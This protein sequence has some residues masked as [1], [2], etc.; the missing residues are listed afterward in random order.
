MNFKEHIPVLLEEVLTVFLNKDISLFIDATLG[1][2]GHA[3]SLLRSHP[4]IVRYH[5][6]DRDPKAIEIARGN[7]EEFSNKL[8]IHNTSFGNL[9]NLF[10][11]SSIDGILADI[12]LSSLQ[13]DDMTR[14]FSFKSDEAYLDMRM[15]YLSGR[16]AADVLNQCSEKELAD[17]FRELGE[18]PYW[19]QSAKAIVAFRRRNKFSTVGSLKESL[20][21]VFPRFRLRKKISPLTLIFQALRIYV[22]NELEELT[23]LIQEAFMLLADKG[24]FACISFHSL[25]D[26]IIKWSFKE[27]QDQ[28][29]GRI[30]T[31]KP[32]I[33]SFEE[34]KKNRRSRSAKLR[35]F[36][37]SFP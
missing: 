7:L 11:P 25:E 9:K 23:Q 3:L 24:R 17:I 37:K 33:A 13:L 14:G 28:G 2:G 10:S 18:E 26:R 22:N 19:R 29:M 4:E 30:I 27:A 1:V 21:N 16:T 6:I 35:V 31:K 34:V 15:N 5:G 36:E 8:N 12:G 20:Q 32:I